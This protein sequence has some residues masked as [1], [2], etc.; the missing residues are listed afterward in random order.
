MQNRITRRSHITLT[1]RTFSDSSFTP[2]YEYLIP[3]HPNILLKF[4]TENLVLRKKHINFAVAKAA[5]QP[6]WRDG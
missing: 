3:V 1:F 2:S 5:M 6:F 4:F